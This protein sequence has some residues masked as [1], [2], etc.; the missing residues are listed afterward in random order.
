M[1]N[2]NKNT[3]PLI[4]LKDIV[5][6]PR[7]IVPLVVGRE[8]SMLALQEALSDDEMIVMAT[9]REIGIEDPAPGDIYRVGTLCKILQ[10]FRLPDGTA[11]VLAEGLHRVRVE[12]YLAGLPFPRVR[13]KRIT[14]KGGA[15]AETAALM[16]M[17]VGLFESYVSLNPRIPS[18]V[19][20]SVAGVD[21]ADRL[22][23][24]IAAHLMVKTEVR[25]K[26]LEAVEPPGRLRLIG[27]TLNSEIEILKI[28]KEITGKVRREIEKSQR[29]LYLSEQLRAIEEELGREGRAAG[30][31]GEIRR[32]I[33]AAGMPQEVEEKALEEVTKLSRM[34]LL[35]PESTVCRNYLEWLLAMPW[36]SAT[37]DNLNLRHARKFLDDDHYDLEKPKERIIEYL[38]VRRLTGGSGGT[39]L[40]LVGPP[41]VG[42]TS[43]ARSIA[44]AVGRNFIRVSLG[45]VRDEA[46]IRGHRRTYIGSMPGRII[47]SIRKVKSRN[48]VFLLDEVDKLCRDYRGDP[49][50]A[51]LEV[52]DPEQ[53]RYFNDHYLEVD[54]DLSNVM[55][56]TT[57]NTPHA[58]HPTLK[59]RLEIIEM[60]GY[61]EWDK[62]KIAEQFLMPK[63]LEVHGLGSKD[64]AITGA[65]IMRMIRHYTREAGVRELERQ[66]SHICR[67]VARKK[68]ES[69]KKKRVT[70]TGKNLAVYLG[71]PKYA[72]GRKYGRREAGVVTGLVWT[73][74]GGDV[75]K[76]EA[77]AL[78]G[79]GELTLTGKLGEVMAESAKAALSY[80]RSR[81]ER[82]G[83]DRNFYKTR[84]IHIHVPEGAIPKDGPSAG[85]TIAAAIFSAL[86][87]SPVRG[88]LAMTGEI[89]LRGQVLKVGGVKEKILAARRAGIRTVILPRDN[90]ADQEDIPS[91]VNSK[92]KYILVD[93]MDEV[94]DAAFSGTKRKPEKK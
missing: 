76:V 55:F 51:L 93:H 86:S 5:M 63:Q 46:E 61:S 57:A 16:R 32:Q 48:P 3:F 7:M 92:M 25:Q 37:R 67:K 20:A 14:P 64:L 13:A 44:R 38:A 66:I 24:I 34:P 17:T 77:T 6:F 56:I 54:F 8:K 35:S 60:T 90:A 28:E 9:Q 84:D 10:I 23:D 91:H 15:D 12:K 33:D 71:R 47:Q 83:L 31:I 68:V 39:I 69:R 75:I 72:P 73:E 41:G 87:G 81:A 49:A 78:P 85:I 22:A 4:P 74:V 43:L 27:E 62:R 94:L 82:F 29:N 89:T 30:E 36:S 19:A 59:D 52:L 80:I 2:R 42:K 18:E 79:K 58:I 11:K 88:D 53:N 45:G 65:A 26:I 70:V 1:A 40:C 50:S 21:D